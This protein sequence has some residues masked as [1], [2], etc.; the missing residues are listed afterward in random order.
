[1]GYDTVVVNSLIHA[2]KGRGYFYNL[3][4]QEIYNLYMVTEMSEMGKYLE[5]YLTL[6]VGMVVTSALL[7]LVSVTVVS[8]ALRETQV[9]VL[10]F[11]CKCSPF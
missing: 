8:F 4:T 9:R 1:M 2:F 7:Y 6:K 3:Q 10:N 5:D 11:S